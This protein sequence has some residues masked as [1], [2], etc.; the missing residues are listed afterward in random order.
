LFKVT[1]NDYLKKINFIDA[2]QTKT[3]LVKPKIICFKFM[4]TFTVIGKLAK[5]HAVEIIAGI[6]LYNV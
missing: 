1:A 3:D 2:M 4:K 5:N 6:V